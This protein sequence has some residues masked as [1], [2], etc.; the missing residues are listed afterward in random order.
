MMQFRQTKKD[1]ITILGNAAQGR[2]QVVG[3]QV[4]TIDAAEVLND[5]RR[6][7]VFYGEGDFEKSHAGLSGPTEHDVTYRI[8]LAASQPAKVNLAVIKDETSTQEQVAAALSCFQDASGLVDESFDELLDIV[9]QILMDGRNIHL[10]Q[11]SPP[12]TAKNR[13]VSGMRKDEPVPQGEYVVLTGV[14]MFTCRLTEEV[15]GDI[16]VDAAGDAYDMKLDLDGD[17]N[18]QTGVTVGAKEG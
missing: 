1:L 15:E 10:G 4:Q 6:V 5:N 7:Q 13:W 9:Y 18:E 11:D 16:G 8:E 17:N 3:Y 12:Y 14:I 2:F